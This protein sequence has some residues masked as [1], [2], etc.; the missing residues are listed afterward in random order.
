MRRKDSY[1]SV[2]HCV[3]CGSAANE[4]SLTDEHIIPEMIGG[5]LIF[6]DA[7]CGVCNDETHAFEGHACDVY[8]P[9][10]RQLGFPSKVKGRRA[11]ERDAKEK[12]I[13]GADYGR[14]KIPAN[15]FPAL[16][17]SLTFPMPAILFNLPPN[18]DPLTG[19]INAIE[20]APDFGVRLQAVQRKYRTHKVEI[21]GVDKSHRMDDGDYG[22]MLA[23]I[24]HAYAV[25][26]LGERKFAPLLTHIVKGIRPYNLT[27]LIGSQPQTISEPTALHEISVED[28]FPSAEHL[29]V[30]RIRL[31]APWK[32]PAHLVVTGVRL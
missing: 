21:V 25:A 24:A 26:A 8:R 22:R 2:G 11:R 6:E 13:V 5:E 4:A 10:R 31:F 15:E 12:F 16:M 1:A 20:L 9:I 19:S 28:N 30:V 3:Y 14:I 29:V 23:K 18:D 7:S 32:T 27:Y 17:I